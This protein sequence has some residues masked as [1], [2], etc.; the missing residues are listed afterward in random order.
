MEFHQVILASGRSVVRQDISL[1]NRHLA[2]VN[3]SDKRI[4]CALSADIGESF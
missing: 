1:R 4:F 3:S 2:S